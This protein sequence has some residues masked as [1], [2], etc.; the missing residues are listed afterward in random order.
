MHGRLELLFIERFSL[1]AM[2]AR[3][4]VNEYI[5]V[6]DRAVAKTPSVH[7]ISIHILH[8]SRCDGARSYRAL[9]RRSQCDRFAFENVW[10]HT[11]AEETGTWMR[12]G[13][14]CS[15]SRERWSGEAYGA[16][17]GSQASQAVVMA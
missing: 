14:F 17:R 4:C 7:D 2:L 3:R 8:C 5:D 10:C 16:V 6:S 13:G 1:V 15:V 11:I 12:T 9:K